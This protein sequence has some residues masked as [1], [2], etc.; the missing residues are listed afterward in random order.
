MGYSSFLVVQVLSIN[1]IPAG[2]LAGDAEAQLVRKI[3]SVDHHLPEP[4]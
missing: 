4:W 2:D 3:A 1:S